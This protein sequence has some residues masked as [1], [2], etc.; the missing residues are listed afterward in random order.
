[1]V[2]VSHD[3]AVVARMAD[4]IVVMYAGRVVESGP[5]DEV[6][7]RPRHPYTRALVGAIPDFRRPRALQGIPGVA[8]GVGEWPDGC[9]VRAP[10]LVRAGALPRR[11]ARARGGR[12]GRTRSGAS[13]GTSSS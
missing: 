5:V 3:L 13:A 9:S 7:S 11:R 8:V 4:R 1:M 12:A 10:V 2:Y 6:I